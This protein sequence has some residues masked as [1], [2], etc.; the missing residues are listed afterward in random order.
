MLP[1]RRHLTKNDQFHFLVCPSGDF[2]IHFLLY[3]ALSK[4][5]FII[6]KL[7][8]SAKFI[9]LF[10]FVLFIMNFPTLFLSSKSLPIFAFQSRSKNVS[11]PFLFLL[12]HLSDC[13]T[14]PLPFPLHCILVH[15]FE[16]RLLGLI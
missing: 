6:F 13:K 4:K 15:I 16:C 8:L 7:F 5:V 9:R 14:H 3:Y 10:L 12:L 1:L 11:T 2:H